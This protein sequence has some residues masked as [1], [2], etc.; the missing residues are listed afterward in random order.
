M[1]QG[2]IKCSI[3]GHKADREETRILQNYVLNLDDIKEIF[4]SDLYLQEFKNGNE[5][6]I[7]FIISFMERQ[8]ALKVLVLRYILF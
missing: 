7:T 3:V 5:P 2:W 4:I 6:I 8:N 1:L